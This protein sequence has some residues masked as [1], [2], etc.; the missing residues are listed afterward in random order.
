MKLNLFQQAEVDS[1]KDAELSW[2]VQSSIENFREDKRNFTEDKKFQRFA[3]YRKVG[4]IVNAVI[5][6]REGFSDTNHKLTER[7]AAKCLWESFK[8][9]YP[10]DGMKQEWNHWDELIF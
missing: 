4:S 1:H 7:E 5:A 8:E 2:V 6:E 10:E 3:L 9:M